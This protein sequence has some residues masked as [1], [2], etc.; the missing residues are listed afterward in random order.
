MQ[1]TLDIDDDVLGAAEA[2]AARTQR[3]AG[4]VISELVRKGLKSIGQGR[5][6]DVM[7]NG[8]EVIPAVDR[9][10]TY[11]EVKSLLEDAEPR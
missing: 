10:V 3:T 2:L 7:V 6:S 4:E 1:T 8:F 9:V 11:E 5:V